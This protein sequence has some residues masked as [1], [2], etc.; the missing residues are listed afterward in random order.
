[1]NA[2]HLFLLT[3]HCY[4]EGTHSLTLIM[5]SGTNLENINITE[6]STILVTI[7]DN[8]GTEIIAS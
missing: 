8:E 5:I 6:A 3:I 4:I 2:Q 7:M 1:M